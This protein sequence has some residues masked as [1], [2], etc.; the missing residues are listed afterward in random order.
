V[1]L[2]QRLLGP[3]LEYPLGTDQFGRC[4][5]SRLVYGARATLGA[6][7]LVLALALT[8]GGALGS[9]A[10]LGGPPWRGL[11]ERTIEVGL[12]LPGLVVAIGLVGLFGPGLLNGVAAVAATS[13]AVPARLTRALLRGE[14][15]APH[16]LAARALGASPLLL[17]RRHILLGVAGRLGVAA[18]VELGRVILALSSLA[19]LGLGPQPPLAE[20][21]AMLSEG[22]TYFLA[23]P[24]LILLPAAAVV[25]TTGACNLLADRLGATLDR[26]S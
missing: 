14:A 18:A 24:Q 16:V 7:L 12:G 20:W 5:L 10:A 1:A 11:A 15:A 25:L 17:W 19:F 3:S 8:V 23:A 13:W 2:D 26:R 6:A 22:R 21:G 9:L 4:L